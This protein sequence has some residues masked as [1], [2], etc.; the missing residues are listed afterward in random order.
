M[1]RLVTPSRGSFRIGTGWLALAIVGWMM[2]PL[3]AQTVIKPRGER[4]PAPPR[5]K[6]LS[7]RESTLS[8]IVTKASATYRKE[9]GSQGF[10]LESSEGEP[11]VEWKIGGEI[12]PLPEGAPTPARVVEKRVKL[13]PHE[14]KLFLKI[15]SLAKG[16]PERAEEEVRFSGTYEAT[17]TEGDWAEYQ[18]GGKLKVR[19]AAADHERYLKEMQKAYFGEALLAK[20]VETFRNQLI[21]LLEQKLTEPGATPAQEIEMVRALVTLVKA[22]PET[23]VV[24]VTLSYESDP[25]IFALEGD[26]MR[27][28]T[29]KQT[30]TLRFNAKLPAM[31]P[32]PP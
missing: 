21:G 16:A 18:K 5:L 1:Q 25:E 29:E 14:D 8:S 30:T 24:T 26:T 7:I 31:A 4:L 2:I 12:R 3:A 22:H 9:A 15:E 17:I 11:V 10:L 23:F 28:T 32:G 20:H 6:T 19:I 27:S 13:I